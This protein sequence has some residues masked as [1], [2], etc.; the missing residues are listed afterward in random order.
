MCKPGSKT[1]KGYVSR[2]VTNGTETFDDLC[3]TAGRNTTMHRA[4]LKMA[5][6]LFMDA[7][8]EALMNGKIVD[9]GTVGKLYPSVSGT[10]TETAEAQQLADLTP[11][12]NF[13]PSDE[14]RSAILTAKLAWTNDGKTTEE[15]AGDTD[16]TPTPPTQGTEDN[17]LE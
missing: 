10:W 12:V 9:L 5:N 6:E 4:E 8:R 2:V 13:R 16:N 17:P 15:E 3:A 14:V 7:V 1:D 11:K